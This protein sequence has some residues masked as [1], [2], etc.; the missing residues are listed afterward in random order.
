[1]RMRRSY[2][3]W[4]LKSWSS[5]D[6]YLIA[7]LT[8]WAVCQ[9]QWKKSNKRLGY[10]YQSFAVFSLHIGCFIWSVLLLYFKVFSVSVLVSLLLLLYDLFSLTARSSADPVTWCYSR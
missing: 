7:M 6:R 9:S 5:V 8:K 2:S 10:G 1:M 4:M 3:F